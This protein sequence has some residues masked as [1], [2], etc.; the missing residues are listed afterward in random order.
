[1]RAR[2]RGQLF[3]LAIIT[4]WLIGCE[5]DP[6]PPNGEGGGG[7]SAGAAGQGGGADGGGDGG[8]PAD[9][10]PTDVEV[11]DA[12]PPDEGSAGAD[13]DAAVDQEVVDME[14]P[15]AAVLPDLGAPVDPPSHEQV[16]VVSRGDETFFVWATADGLVRLHLDANGDAMGGPELID[17]PE[18]PIERVVG[19]T[20]AGDPWIAYGAADQLVILMQ[21]DL[22]EQT[23][24]E[25]P[26]LYG[27]PLLAAA[28]RDAMVIA[29]T[30]DGLLAWRVIDRVSL[31][32]G[33]LIIDDIGLPMPDDAAGASAGVVLH[34]ASAGQCIQLSDLDWRAIGSFTCIRG[35]ARMISDGQ[36]ALVT[37]LYDFRNNTFIAAR[38]V[39]GRGDS[40][41]VD[42]YQFS[43]Q[44]LFPNDGP[45]RPVVGGRV[46]GDDAG[47]LVLTI[48]GIEGAYSSVETWA[49]R[50]SVE[51][52]FDT[53]RA[54]AQ[55]ALLN[56][57]EP[58]ICSGDG[59][60]C[61]VDEDC[62]G[63]STCDGAVGAMH[64]ITL[65]FR[66][67]GYPLI[68]WLPLAPRS[69]G[70]PP[71]EANLDPEC[72][73]EPER[74]DLIDQDCDGLPDNGRCCPGTSQVSYRWETPLRV[75]RVERDGRED[76]EFVIAETEHLGAYRVLY[77]LEGTTRWEGKSALLPQGASDSPGNIGVSVTGAVNG[78]FLLALGGITALIAQAANAEGEAGPWT[79]FFRHPSRDT[80]EEHPPKAQVNLNCSDVLAAATL[81]HRSPPFGNEL[82]EH[83][84]VVCPDR[85]SR[86]HAIQGIDDQ[87][88]TL[89]T[90]NLPDS[91]IEWATINHDRDDT[92]SIVVGFR[93]NN[94]L[95]PWSTRRFR[96]VAGSDDP[97][98]LEPSPEQF[99]LADIN[100]ADPLWVHPA[101]PLGRPPIQI[102]SDG[103]VRLALLETNNRGNPF[104][105]WREA[106]LTAN[107]EKVIFANENFHVYASNPVMPDDGF[108]EATGW[109]GI[110]VRGDDDY[111][112][113]WSTEPL[114]TVN[115]P[116]AYWHAPRRPHGRYDLVIL[117]PT[118]QTDRRW[119][120]ITRHTVCTSP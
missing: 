76:Y 13:L 64:A 59:A 51:Y 38:S 9:M 92:L 68:D 71:Y 19:L 65:G 46:G 83:L 73:P 25:L 28:G 111:Y 84:V 119:R 29:R 60:A 7:G 48:I 87:I 113:L 62:E 16:A 12:G 95:G 109:W 100:A 93:T 41:G 80:P 57:R 47:R 89:E 103:R 78:R 112:N 14:E 70:S 33:P 120:M 5:A 3:A 110:D 22:V 90:L 96:M 32:Q 106:L 18:Y 101:L 34:F 35:S 17:T 118:D 42:T 75:A 66:S 94:G 4:A 23:R 21:V 72:A 104:I 67:D 85:I 63:Q 54:I 55:R 97:P 27:A 69:V 61:Q 86:I 39:Y 8:R 6:L 26:G 36:R 114:F 1:M 15:D 102:T 116:V 11:D 82:G 115:G 45:R 91:G 10:A 40:F 37:H 2:P 105:D 58:G 31:D 50:D 49:D 44:V 20:I 117:T 30:L 43:D 24:T 74:C 56:R 107:P 52:P 88:N 98:R 53:V 81:S 99:Q 79:A 108:E 77:R